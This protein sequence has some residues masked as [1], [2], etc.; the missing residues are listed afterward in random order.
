MTLIRRA[1]RRIRDLYGYRFEPERLRILADVYWRTTLLFAC[2]LSAGMFAYGV[3]ILTDVLKQAEGGA[4]LST[5][6]TLPLDR[7][8]LR[9]ALGAFGARAERMETA[10]KDL[11]PVADP[12][13]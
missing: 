11:G 10:V 1:F 13:R 3:W 12:S 8:K 7:T 2:A 9:E 4:T 6:S 5:K